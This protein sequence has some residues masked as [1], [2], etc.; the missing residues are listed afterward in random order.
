MWSHI[1][2]GAFL[3]LLFLFSGVDELKGNT[4][5][6]YCNNTKEIVNLNFIVDDGL[7]NVEVLEKV[8]LWLRTSND[9]L[10]NS[11]IPIHKR[12]NSIYFNE[13][14]IS[15]YVNKRNPSIGF[16]LMD[17]IKDEK[18]ILLSKWSLMVYI[19]DLSDESELL[20]YTKPTVYPYSII[21]DANAD[22]HI[23]EHESGHL[24][25][26]F[27]NEFSICGNKVSI[28]VESAPIE[29]ISYSYSIGDNANCKGGNNRKNVYNYYFDKDDQ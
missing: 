26:A 28:M 5:N 8:N 1:N 6:N 23:L 16:L 18:F 29:D 2:R 27:H 21:I 17:E 9:I 19:M 15:D 7:N 13:N 20:G 24:S 3:F 25:G 22:D 10:S 4:L 14:S 11:C 12:V